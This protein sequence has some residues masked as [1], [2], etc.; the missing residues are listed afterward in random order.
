MREEDEVTEKKCRQGEGKS[1]SDDWTIFAWRQRRE[2]KFKRRDVAVAQ[3]T[4]VLITLL[5]GGR[6]DPTLGKWH[7]KGIRINWRVGHVI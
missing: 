1:A 5:I 2:K 3:R 6:E 4:F 7:R